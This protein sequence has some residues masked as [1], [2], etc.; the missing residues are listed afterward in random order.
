MEWKK[1]H[2]TA[3]GSARYASRGK[4]VAKMLLSDEEEM[5]DAIKETRQGEFA[6]CP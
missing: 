5:H 2:F 1:L 6:L 4:H 3:L